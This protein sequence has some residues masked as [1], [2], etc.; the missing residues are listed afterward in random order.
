MVKTRNQVLQHDP[1]YDL[2]MTYDECMAQYVEVK[3]DDLMSP[4]HSHGW[5][6]PAEY[7]SA[8]GDRKEVLNGPWNMSFDK[9]LDSGFFESPPTYYHI[10]FK[11][12]HQPY[13]FNPKC[14]LTLCKFRWCLP[15]P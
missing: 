5:Q 13:T 1:E 7:D 2:S 10:P 4:F 3:T 8:T 6:K 14:S 12:S 15:H 11:G 9:G